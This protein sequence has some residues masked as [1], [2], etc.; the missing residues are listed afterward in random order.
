MCF[1]FII[2]IILLSNAHLWFSHISTLDSHSALYDVKVVAFCNY[3]R[4]ECIITVVHIYKYIYK[5]M[6]T[7]ISR[8]GSNSL[9]Y[10]LCFASYFLKVLGA[11]PKKGH[12]NHITHKRWGRQTV[13]H[14]TETNSLHSRLKQ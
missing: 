1:D 8:V 2:I 14:Q 5:C 3:M 12:W 9:G 13:T 6:E 4:N 7:H 11:P 10:F